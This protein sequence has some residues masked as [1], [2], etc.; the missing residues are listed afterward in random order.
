[1]NSVTS[2]EYFDPRQK[3]KEV[4]KFIFDSYGLDYVVNALSFSNCITDVWMNVHSGKIGIGRLF[5]LYRYLY[6]AWTLQL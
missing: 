5:R 4:I 3:T 6:V 2:K 1:M